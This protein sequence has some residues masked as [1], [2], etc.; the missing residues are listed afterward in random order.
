MGVSSVMAGD[1]PA[2]LNVHFRDNVPI[3]RFGGQI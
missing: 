2:T 1:L 3:I